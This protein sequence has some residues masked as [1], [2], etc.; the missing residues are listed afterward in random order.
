[1]SKYLDRLHALESGKNA[2]IGSPQN[3]QSL[4]NLLRVGRWGAFRELLHRSAGF[5]MT[6]LACSVKPIDATPPRSA[7]G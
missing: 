2:Y 1:M 3:P 5:S 7:P 6:P 4:M